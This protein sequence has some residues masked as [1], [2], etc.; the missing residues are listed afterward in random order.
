MVGG[1]QHPSCLLKIIKKKDVVA[2]LKLTNY[3]MVAGGAQ[4]P[5]LSVEAGFIV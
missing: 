4:H 3:L 5:L 1:A 2:E